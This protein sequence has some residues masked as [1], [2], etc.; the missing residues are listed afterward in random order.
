TLTGLPK[1]FA[2]AA[3]ARSDASD[4]DHVA[5]P[6]FL[7]KLAPDLVHIPLNRVP[8]L[9]RKPY[10]VTIHDMANIFYDERQSNLHMQLR[11]Y[12]FRR[13]LVR[14]DRVIAV[15]EATSREV[16]K[17]MGVPSHRIRVIY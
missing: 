2:T 7:H 10:V 4:A 9:M 6:I 14:A 8:L 1:N 11:R 12:R 16:Q 13:G 5:F 15:S 3:Y 17:A